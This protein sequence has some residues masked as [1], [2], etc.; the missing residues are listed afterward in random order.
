MVVVVAVVVL[1]AAVEHGCE[2]TG[3]G[4]VVPSPDFMPKKD[5]P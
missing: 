4:D 5:E 2:R 1:N 3:G